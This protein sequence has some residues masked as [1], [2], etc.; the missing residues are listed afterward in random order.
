MKIKILRGDKEWGT[1]SLADGNLDIDG[2]QSLKN[3]VLSLIV[4]KYSLEA[5]IKALPKRLRSYIQAVDIS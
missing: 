4:K 1:V 3:F 5:N 2:D